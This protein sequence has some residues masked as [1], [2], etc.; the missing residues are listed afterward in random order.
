MSDEKYEGPNAVVLEAA[1]LIA[2][3]VRSMRPETRERRLLVTNKE[4]AVVGV[5]TVG[6]VIGG[7]LKAHAIEIQVDDEMR[8]KEVLCKNCGALVKV[9]QGH[10][11]F[12]PNC[13]PG[14]CPCACGKLLH[15]STVFRARQNGY[16]PSCSACAARRRVETMSPEQRSEAARR[17]R[18]SKT[19]DQRSDIARKAYA[20]RTSE[21][22]AE[23]KR[24]AWETRKANASK[25]SAA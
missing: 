10:G 1:G 13:C 6:E 3:I 18:A 12:V 14:G 9:R 8:P 21:Q 2:P 25:R 15:P 4:G 22:Q 23:S 20:A 17:G 7:L 16:A 5:S 24:K 19:P 11:G